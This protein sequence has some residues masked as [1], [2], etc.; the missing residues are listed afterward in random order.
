MMK[1]IKINPKEANKLLCKFP[2]NR[3]AKSNKPLENSIKEYG[4]HFNP[5]LIGKKILST[6]A[7]NGSTLE[8]GE[9]Y[10]V[11]DG[12]HRVLA[13]INLNLPIVC[14]L[15]ETI[16]YVKDKKAIAALQKAKKWTID[17][18]VSFLSE[19]DDEIAIKLQEL[20]YQYNSFSSTKVAEIFFNGSTKSPKTLIEDGKYK[21]DEYKGRW[22]LNAALELGFN[23]T[24]HLRAIK[25]L[26]NK[27]GEFSVDRLKDKLNFETV[28]W[29][30]NEVEIIEQIVRIY[31]TGELF[32][33]QMIKYDPPKK[34]YFASDVRLKALTRAN[35]QCEYI[36]ENNIRC[37]DTN[38]LEYDHDLAF[39][40]GGSNGIEN[41]RVL[42]QFHNRSKSSK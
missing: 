1:I 36:D 34:R 5:V 42:C 27:N 25:Y 28:D 8:H 39:V 9:Y 23:N 19:Y 6:E 2:G 33:D 37:E 3:G 40:N 11:L 12:Q 29:S 7:I 32:E 41:C 38:N 24:S 21:I 10:P 20:I 4:R 26:F 18:F 16:D 35:G 13:L 17:D 14:V 31:N 22:V 15:D 30:T